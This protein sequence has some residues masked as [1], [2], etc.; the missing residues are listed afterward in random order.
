MSKVFYK[1]EDIEDFDNIQNF[2]AGQGTP[3][4]KENAAPIDL[5]TESQ[6]EDVFEKQSGKSL[7]VKET[8]NIRRCLLL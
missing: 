3:T 4:Y 2:F 6:F 1:L 7:F 8:K 5:W